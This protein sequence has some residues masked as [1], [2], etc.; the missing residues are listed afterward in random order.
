M[1]DKQK[2]Q[3]PTRYIDRQMRVHKRDDMHPVHYIKPMTGCPPG[4]VRGYRLDKAAALTRGMSQDDL[5]GIADL[6]KWPVAVLVNKEGFDKAVSDRKEIRDAMAR[7]ASRTVH[8]AEAR[9][10]EA[11]RVA[12]AARNIALG[13]GAKQAAKQ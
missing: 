4:T 7:D 5:A 6:R 2:Q 1:S 11:Y 10:K 9:A 3:R 8:E 12:Q 13:A